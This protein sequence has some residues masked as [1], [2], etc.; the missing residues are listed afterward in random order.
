MNQFANLDANQ[1]VFF[2]RELERVKSE[3]FMVE[4][5][6]LQFRRLFPIDNQGGPGIDSTTITVWDQVGMA[7]II[8]GYSDDLPR[9]DVKGRQITVPIRTIGTS[10]GYNVQ[11]IASAQ[12]VNRPLSTMRADAARR[13]VEEKLN[14]IAFGVDEEGTDAGLYGLLSH[15]NI[16]T[17]NVTNGGGGFPQWSTKT[18]DEILFDIN[19][20]CAEVMEATKMRERPS[21]LLLPIAQYNILAFTR[22]TDTGESLMSYVLRNS[23]FIRRAEDIIPL[24]ELDGA[25]TGGADVMIVYDPNPTKLQMDIPMELQFLPVQEKGL[26]FVVPGWCRAGGLHIYRPLSLNRK[27]QI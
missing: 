22:L 6:E 1:T 9:A 23:Q 2:Q 21:R 16:P 10:F 5:K 20:A 19:D 15:P 11:E 14:N 24:V 4:Y 17:G 26:S 27:E 8:G 7:K 13:A 25:G 3:V 12:L 18:P